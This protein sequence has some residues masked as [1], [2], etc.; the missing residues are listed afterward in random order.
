[1]AFKSTL[2]LSLILCVVS[3]DALNDS[4]VIGVL[5]QSTPS[6]KYG[7]AYIAASYV[8]FVE[9]A[10]ARVVPLLIDQ[11]D[12]Y[13]EKMF[14]SLNGV[15]FPGGGMDDPIHSPYGKAGKMF[16]DLAIKSYDERGDYFPIWGTCLGMELLVRI[17]ANEDLLTS[18]DASE[19][20]WPLQLTK[21]FKDSRLFHGAEQSVVS[22]LS[23]ENVTYNSHNLG[24]TPTNFSKSSALKSFYRVL[25]T[26]VDKN[27]KVFISTIEAMYYPIY[28]VQFHPEK[29]PYEWE[30]KS[31]NHSYDAVK[32]TQFFADFF[33][34]EARKS[35]HSFSP[36][37]LDKYL[38]Y[39]YCPIFT[40]SY[41]EQGYFFN[42]SST[43]R[44]K[45]TY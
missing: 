37:T 7:D 25:S 45:L 17:T 11:P 26:N 23:N 33:V 19:V 14:A 5:S 39:N 40:D 41:F 31:I 3:S 43:L 32:A 30:S 9:S 13:Y 18:T 42:V 16:Y 34:S 8:K 27:G 15:L 22:I 29:N 2:F 21:D 12:S 36:G 10:G 4:P 44:E 38:I 1:M 35:Y 6:K 28:G 20:S 24:L